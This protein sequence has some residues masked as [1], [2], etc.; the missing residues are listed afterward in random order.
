MLTH[1]NVHDRPLYICHVSKP[2]YHTSLLL[3]VITSLVL[4]AAQVYFTFK[5]Y[6]VNKQRFIQ[7]V[8]QVLNTSIEQYFADKAKANIFIMRES[9][10]DTLFQGKRSIAYA[11][12]S[13]NIDSLLQIGID[14]NQSIKTTGFTHIWSTT[15]EGSNPLH[16]DSVIKKSNDKN[17]Q[18]LTLRAD[19][20]TARIQHLEILTQKV[21]ISITE[22]LLDLGALYSTMEREL[23]ERQLEIDFVLNQENSGGKTSIGTMDHAHFLSTEATSNYLG[24]YHSIT[25]DFENAT[26]I[27]L[28]N[29]IGELILS[30][31]LIGLVVGTLIHLYRT[32][33]SQKQ[34][35]MIKDDLISNITHEFKTP[36]AT[37]FSALEGVTSFNKSNDPEKTKRY[38]SL[39]KD[40]LHK[41]NNM[42]EKMLET[43]TIDQGKLTLNKEELEGAQWTKTLVE[44]FQ[45]I[46]SNKKIHWES[47]V[48]AKVIFMDGFHMENA[49][50]NLIDN[51]IKYGGDQIVVRCIAT[52]TKVKWEVEDNG[53]NIPA[54]QREK[55]FEKLYRIP[56][57][58]THDVK[59]FGIGLYYA[60]TIAELHGGNLSLEVTNGLTR[61]TLSI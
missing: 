50:S 40:Q 22:D 15:D 16:L 51:A 14:S 24:E 42:V 17:L 10:S 3:I 59:G 5:N 27:I 18:K 44:R 48:D 21:M 35:A 4:I 43:A 32:I 26:L 53:G 38:L 60:R 45:L 1:R 29:G 33:Y 31:L 58:N 25:I 2:T 11:S 19:V 6:E 54:S 47:N 28:R 8:Q 46:E 55:I 7:D 52:G 23:T 36:I 37:I 12:R 41:L 30:M 56:T 39:S 9:S 49:L 20:D 57:G 13:S 34:L 61:F